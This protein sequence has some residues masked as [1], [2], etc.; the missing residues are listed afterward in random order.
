MTI[1]L[2]E[3]LA[4]LREHGYCG[5]FNS[6]FNVE[7]GDA[8][9]FDEV[10]PSC[11]NCYLT[12]T[13]SINCD[14]C[15][16]T[17]NNFIKFRSGEGDGIY[18]ALDICLEGDEPLGGLLLFDSEAV[19]SMLAMMENGSS[20]TFD[21]DLSDLIQDIEGVC[22]G[23]INL[24]SC[25]HCY[26]PELLIKCDACG[27]LP[28]ELG[29][30]FFVGD[31][32]LDNSGNYAIANFWAEPGDFSVF[33]FGKRQAALILP[34]NQLKYE[35]TSKITHKHEWSGD[36]IQE[37]SLGSSSDNVRSHVRPAG[38]DAVKINSTLFA[39]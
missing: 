34:N 6:V 5:V 15:G 26:E 29:Y 31:A 7:S 13:T 18:A 23:H 12:R 17:S 25:D 2:F 28:G 16:R 39:R 35:V 3:I 32:G 9:I 19:E 14:T 8:A 21:L 38:K 27:L 11:D 24:K 30:G 33:L 4:V 36:K 37:F 22:I 1:K 20:P 10:I